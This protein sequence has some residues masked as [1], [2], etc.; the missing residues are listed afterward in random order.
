MLRASLIVAPTARTAQ[1]VRRTD[2]ADQATFEQVQLVAGPEP[3]RHHSARPARRRLEPVGRERA[4]ADAGKPPSRVGE[5]RGEG[6]PEAGPLP[7]QPDL[8]KPQVVLP[9]DVQDL[10]DTLSRS[11][12]QRAEGPPATS[13]GASSTRSARPTDNE[14]TGQLL[15][16]LLAP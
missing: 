12:R 2:A 11:Q 6:Q 8:S 9:P 4:R 15:D 5:R 13:S 16:Y 1:P 10:L 14:T 7:G 3:A